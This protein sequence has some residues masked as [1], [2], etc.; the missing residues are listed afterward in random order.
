MLN[1]FFL[2]GF[3][4]ATGY[5]RHGEWIDQVAATHHDL[6]AFEDY[7]LLREAGIRGARESIRW[8]LVDRGGSYD[9]STVEPLLDASQ[10][11]GVDVI[12]DLFHYGYPEHVDLFS[13]DFAACFA[14]YCYAAA[15]YVAARTDG[16][17]YFTPINEP[18]YYSWAAGEVGVFAPHQKG[19]GWEL[20]VNLARA[21]IRAIDAIRA[22]CP[23]ARMVNADPLCRV[24]PPLDR[25]DL[26]AQADGFNEGPVF[27]SWDMLCGRLLPELGGTP[28]HLDI[29]GIN[30]YWTNQWDLTRPET[31]L[32]DDDS[33]RAP[34]R[35]LVRSVWERY[36]REIVITET[37]HRDE[38]RPVWI[39]EL[40]D[41]CEALL[42][43]DV[44]LRG[45]CLYPILG[46]PEWHARQ[47]WT[48]MGLWDLVPQH[49]TLGRVLCEPMLEALKEA[50]RLEARVRRPAPQEGRASAAMWDVDAALAQAALE[51]E[52]LEAELPDEIRP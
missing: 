8:P 39:R 24:V 12:W 25:P 26:Q 18:S 37:S 11:N 34:L 38:M 47:Q 15:S 30:Y 52:A 1:S 42:D 49:P 29:I 40:A 6:C 46:M 5:N 14:D 45:V 50:Q 23:G 3:E 36:G 9:F 44:P 41:E 33:R 20:K 4:C 21:A 10:Q 43:E 2:A 13:S 27:E 32:E 16:V 28:E 22:A 7:R 51:D 48:R 31:P 17:C 19:R 35:S